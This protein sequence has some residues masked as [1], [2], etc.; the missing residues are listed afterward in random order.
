MELEFDKEIDAILR[1]SAG[2]AA[3]ASTAAA[4]AHADA[5]TIAAFA[6]NALPDKVKMLYMEHF[7]DCDGCR[8]QLSH[9]ILLNTGADATAAPL[10]SVPVAEVAVPWYQKLFKTQNLA[11]AM[12]AIVLTFGGVLGYLVLQNRNAGGNSTVSQITEQKPAPRDPYALSETA[13]TAANTE[14]A[15][16]MPMAGVPVTNAN[17]VANTPEGVMGRPDAGPRNNTSLDTDSVSDASPETEAQPGRPTTV[18]PPP[19]PVTT[20]DGTLKSADEKKEDS[21]KLAALPKDLE[22]TKRK[23]A[24]DRRGRDAPPAP[25][26]GVGPSRSGPVQNTQTQLNNNAGE[27]PVSRS[28]GGKRFENRDGAWYDSAYRG[29]A[30]INVRRGTDEYKNLD[31]GLR[32]IANNLGGTVVI[33]WKDKAYRVH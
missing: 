33:V 4:S 3:V 27:M 12:G 15:N 5:D 6:E 2:G 26:K 25:G 10:I 9:A 24:D 11:L 7:A 22:I 1:R 19:P 13:N 17:S 16:T 31:G 18:S 20:T 28:V 32:S 21:A 30:T 23:E 8:K 29:Q 14:A